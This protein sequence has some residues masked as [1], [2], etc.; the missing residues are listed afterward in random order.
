[1]QTHLDVL[2]GVAAALPRGSEPR[3]FDEQIVGT[4]RLEGDRE[5]PLLVAG[6]GRDL[7]TRRLAHSQHAEELAEFVAKN[8]NRGAREGSAVGAEHDAVQVALAIEEGRFRRG[9]RCGGA[10]NQ[11]R[12]AGGS[13]V[14]SRQVSR[15]LVVVEGRNLIERANGV[16]GG[17]QGIG[18]VAPPQHQAD[19]SEHHDTDSDSKL[20]RHG[21]PSGGQDVRRETESR[22]TH[23]REEGEAPRVAASSV[24]AV[25]RAA[26]GTQ[27]AG[28]A[29]PRRRLADLLAPRNPRVV[30]PVEVAQDHRRAVVLRQLEDRVREAT[31][32]PHPRHLLAGTGGGSRVAI[33]FRRREFVE[34][35]HTLVATAAPRE[36]DGHGAQPAPHASEGRR[37][38]RAFVRR[39]PRLLRHIVRDRF[40]PDEVQRQPPDPAHLG[41]EPLGVDLLFRFGHR[42]SG[43][44]SVLRNPVTDRLPFFGARTGAGGETGMLESGWNPT[45]APVRDRFSPAPERRDGGISRDHCADFNHGSRDDGR[46]NVES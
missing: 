29:L 1:M 37:S 8:V 5:E 40:I 22:G 34:A 15:G 43:R 20:D 39:E 12:A 33:R 13:R 46:S 41:E 10:D 21:S 42:V 26:Q 3:R 9:A 2:P 4:P 32:H 16:R 38:R 18:I 19:D 14:L 35:V 28:D 44:K 25:E 36:V 6:A 27:T 30:E 7:P 24:L 17:V 11:G 23:E 31:L 45:S